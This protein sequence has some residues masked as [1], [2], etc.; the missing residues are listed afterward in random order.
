[1]GETLA[2]FMEK[3]QT[4]E[5]DDAYGACRQ[6]L[7]ELLEQAVSADQVETVQ[8]R[9]FPDSAPVLDSERQESVEK[10][11]QDD[12]SIYNNEDAKHDDASLDLIPDI[13]PAAKLATASWKAYWVEMESLTGWSIRTGG[14]PYLYVRPGRNTR[15]E[16]KLGVDY[17][18]TLEDVQAFARQHYGWCGTS[19]VEVICPRCRHLVTR[20]TRQDYYPLPLTTHGI[21]DL[22]QDWPPQTQNTLRAARTHFTEEHEG[23]ELPWGIRVKNSNRGSPKLANGKPDNSKYRR[24]LRSSPKKKAAARSKL[25]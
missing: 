18:D 7:E 10:D 15:G 20:Y 25:G 19:K 9:L 17:F 3:Y 24:M 12:F 1:M 11:E 16:S 22:Y 5:N 13:P 14:K 6:E 21:V 2:E 8:R 4:N 23:V